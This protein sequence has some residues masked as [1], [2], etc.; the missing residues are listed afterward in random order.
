MKNIL[1][2]INHKIK[3]MIY[4]LKNDTL[5]KINVKKTGCSYTKKTRLKIFFLLEFNYICE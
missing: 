5:I 3:S 1:K 2:K 4:F